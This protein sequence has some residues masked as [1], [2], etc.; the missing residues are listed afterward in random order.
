MFESVV[1]ESPWG[2]GD[3]VPADD[4]NDLNS[5][6]DLDGELERLL[7]EGGWPPDE[8]ASPYGSCAPSGELALDL[9]I[10]T[11]DATHL[12]DESLVEAIV[13]FDR[14]AS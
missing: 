9:D 13:G 7:A 11:A 3:Y 14:L 1:A 8:P 10:G 5:L 6:G 12:S 2:Y 4:L